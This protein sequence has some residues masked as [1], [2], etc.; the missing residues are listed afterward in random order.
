MQIHGFHRKMNTMDGNSCLFKSYVSLFLFSS[1]V[2][3]IKYLQEV[4]KPLSYEI[5]C[6]LLRGLWSFLENLLIA[7]HPVCLHPKPFTLLSSSLVL[8]HH[9]PVYQCCCST[10]Y[11]LVLTMLTWCLLVWPGVR[12][13]GVRQPGT[14]EDGVLV[15][16]LIH[17]YSNSYSGQSGT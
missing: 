3:A 17:W 6:L 14:I 16:S 15:S 2:D 9:A 8:Q 7:S 4:R 10:I 12:W 11:F 1:H 13:R 5:R